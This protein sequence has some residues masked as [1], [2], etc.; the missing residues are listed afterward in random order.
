LKRPP[1]WRITSSTTIL[2]PPK[3]KVK[4]EI[5]LI[6]ISMSMYVV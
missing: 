1:G 4:G 3:E 2:P 5:L 6:K